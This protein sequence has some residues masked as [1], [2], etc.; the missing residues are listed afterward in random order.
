MYI[1]I[2]IFKEKFMSFLLPT[3]SSHSIELINKIERRKLARIS[4]RILD[5]LPVNNITLL[6]SDEVQKLC[7]LAVGS[8]SAEINLIVS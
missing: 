7:A 3:G 6:T 5:S 1:I 4:K 2:E 8:N